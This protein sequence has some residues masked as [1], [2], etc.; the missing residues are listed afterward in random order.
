MKHPLLAGILVA[1]ALVA[2]G[3]PAQAAPERE[4][5]AL[6]LFERFTEAMGG[7]QSMEKLASFRQRSELTIIGQNLTLPLTAVYRSPDKFYMETSLPGIGLSR[8]GYNG[9]TGWSMDPVLGYRELA[10]AELEMLR[11]NVALAKMADF[12][13]AFTAMERLPDQTQGGET[14]AVVRAVNGSGHADRLYFS[15]Q[16]GLLRGWDTVA[17]AGP[18]G[19]VPVKMRF[20]DY[21]EAGSLRVPFRTEVKTPAFD[22]VVSVKEMETNI[23]VDPAIFEPPAGG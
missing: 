19:S 22:S 3:I 15:T 9:K 8:Q 4:A 16:S 10:D 7:R 6:A 2:G 23:E 1:G 13:V 11:Q 12:A 5:D 14:V 20:S 18:V 21:R 17:E